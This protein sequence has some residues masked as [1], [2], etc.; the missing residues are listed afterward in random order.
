VG[1]EASAKFQIARRRAKLV[2]GANCNVGHL[3]LP[4]ALKRRILE[5]SDYGII[6][7]V[8]ASYPPL[9][10]YRRDVARL[11]PRQSFGADD[12]TWIAATLM[13]QRYVDASPADRARLAGELAV[14][15]AVENEVTVASAGLRISTDMD[16]AGALHLATTWLTLLERLVP[17]ARV[18]DFG[19]VLA[20]RARVA[21]RLNATDSAKLLYKEVEHLGERCAEPELTAR[22]WIGY[23]VMARARG[24]NPEAQ[25]W[26][27]VAALVADDTGCTMQSSL[28]HQGLMISAAII[29]DFDQAMIEGGLAF[30]S[31]QNDP[32]RE[33]AVLTN[34]AQL[35]HDTGRHQAALRAF[36]SIVARTTVPRMLLGALGGAATAAAALGAR[37]V[38]EAAAERVMRLSG[39]AWPFPYA[40]ALIELAEAYAALGDA[41]TSDDHRSR[42]RALA[43]AHGFHGLVHR[44]EN[45]PVVAPPRSDPSAPMSFSAAASQVISDVEELEAP[46]DLCTVL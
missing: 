12:G 40:L 6:T 5:H 11:A 2:R 43:E 21:H 37:G 16:E 41:R 19:R 28:A 32:R 45:P 29:G 8:L 22:A 33:A 46:A 24:N 25:R 26:Y 36:A 9:E 3:F 18:L 4:T 23:A 34:I 35:L 20:S 7:T 15:L 30:Q 1:A 14:Y 17:P 38:V 42:G 27:H 44:A 39:T 10:A 31:C 13:L